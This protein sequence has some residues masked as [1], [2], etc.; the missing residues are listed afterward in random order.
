MTQQPAQPA[1]PRTEMKLTPEIKD[2]IGDPFGK[3][4]FAILSYVDES[5]FPNLSFRG[6]LHV[7]S[8]NQL[9][10][11]ARNP[12]GGFL[13]AMNGGNNKVAVIFRNP[14]PNGR[15]QL[16]FKGTARIDDSARDKVYNDIP[17][18]E[19]NSDKE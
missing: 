15:V 16:V 11:W 19:Q 6:S 7:T 18:Q 12:E 14:D 4:A 13:K 10:F 8:D 2:A 5:G 1:P 3:Q 9:A 17:T